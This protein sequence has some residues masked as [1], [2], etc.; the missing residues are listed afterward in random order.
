M[1]LCW[2]I[3]FVWCVDQFNLYHVPFEAVSILRFLQYFHCRALSFSPEPK[4]KNL[5]NQKD[6]NQFRSITEFANFTTQLNWKYLK[7]PFCPIV[8]ANI[9]I[10][11]FSSLLQWLKLSEKKKIILINIYVC[12]C[13]ISINCQIDYDF[14]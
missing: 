4:Q 2:F 9:S 8:D 12:Y 3:Q 1:I 11:Y 7:L 5:K 10:K 13:S 6:F 14:F